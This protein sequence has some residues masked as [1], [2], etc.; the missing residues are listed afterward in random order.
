M[1]EKE[2][3]VAAAGTDLPPVEPVEPEAEATPATP[4]EAAQ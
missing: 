2:L 1:D 3:D 4:E